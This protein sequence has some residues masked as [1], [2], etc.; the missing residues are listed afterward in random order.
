MSQHPSRR[1][2]P[3]RPQHVALAL[4]PVIGMGALTACGGAAESAPPGDPVKVAL[5]AA[6]GTR[7]VQAGDRLRVSAE[8]G[9]LTEV[10]VTDPRGQQLPGGLGNHGTIWISRAK[11]APD[12]KYSVVAR[13]RNAQ[14]GVAAA[15]ESLTTAKAARL[16]TLMLGPGSAGAVAD[17]GR[18]LTITFDF[19]VTDRNEVERRLSVTTDRRTTGSWDW[20]KDGSGRDRVDW[21]PA[22]QWKPGTRVTLRAALNGVDSGGG[23][24]FTDDY[25]LNFTI[26]RSCTDSDMGRVCGKVH[27]GDPV[28]VAAPSL[29]GEDNRTI[30]IG[31]WHDS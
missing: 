22:Q 17:A 28:V 7:T 19:P 1:R 30:G 12:T 31:D 18:P 10:T 6:S 2:R 4:A 8:G 3:F 25:D 26:G 15:K 16:N 20:G 14:G 23:R 9:V 29:R 27:V 13:T 11:T 24:Y 21:H 5:G